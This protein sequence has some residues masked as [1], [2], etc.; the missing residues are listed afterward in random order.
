MAWRGVAWGYRLWPR[1]AST[2]ARVAD[3]LA[4]EPCED[5]EFCFHITRST[6]ASYCSQGASRC[7][8]RLPPFAIRATCSLVHALPIAVVSTHTVAHGKV[9]AIAFARKLMP[10][11]G[12]TANDKM[13]AGRY[14]V[15]LD[16]GS[17]VS[18]CCL[19]RRVL[20]GCV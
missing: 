1:A 17:S 20:P 19:E 4:A 6:H 16:A 12:S 8:F 13:R 14:G 15:V 11:D 5:G 2:A 7:L 3:L 18:T 10:H 9:Y